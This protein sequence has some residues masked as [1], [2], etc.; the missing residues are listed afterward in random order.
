[1]YEIYIHTHIIIIIIIFLKTPI[2]VK[3]NNIFHKYIEFFVRWS[4]F[5]FIYFF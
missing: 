4:P 3:N 2:K 5:V 1:V